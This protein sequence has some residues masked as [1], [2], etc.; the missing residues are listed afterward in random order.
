MGTTRKQCRHGFVHAAVSFAA[1]HLGKPHYLIDR[2]LTKAHQMISGI[3]AVKNLQDAARHM[4]WPDLKSN[5]YWRPSQTAHDDISSN[6]AAEPAAHGSAHGLAPVRLEPLPA[7]WNV[8]PHEWLHQ[9]LQQKEMATM[10]H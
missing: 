1:L 5:S 9:P 8:M 10:A 4:A 6:G 3:Q 2:Q 7:H